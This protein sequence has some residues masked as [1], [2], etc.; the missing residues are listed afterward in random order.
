M[1]AQWPADDEN[2]PTVVVCSH[3]DVQPVDPLDRWTTAPFEP[4]VRGEQIVGRGSADDKGQVYFTLGV[5]AHLAAT[6][7][8]APA[9][10]LKL[11][12]EEE[13]SGS[14]Y[15]VALVTERRDRLRCD[16]VVITDTGMWGPDTPSTC[17]AMRGLTE[18]Q[19]DVHGPDID[20]HSGS[21][22]GAVRNPLTELCGIVAALHD[23][24]VESRSR[25][26]TTTS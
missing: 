6:G 11:L 25:A 23:A 19:V 17:T 20:L 26:S 2:A 5:R 9:V 22:G 3:H 4:F 15:L 10:T 14:P 13:E 18:C 21:F 16:V 7:R 8:T 24:K 12:I 1:F